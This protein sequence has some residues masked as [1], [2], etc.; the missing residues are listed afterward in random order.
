MGGLWK[1]DSVLLTFSELEEAP[2][3]KLRSGK[4][5]R[6]S[7]LM[8][9]EFAAAS[10]VTSWRIADII[11]KG[12]YNRPPKYLILIGQSRPS[13]EQL[14]CD[15]SISTPATAFDRFQDL[16]SNMDPTRRRY[17]GDFQSEHLPKDLANCAS[18]YCDTGLICVGDGSF[19]PKLGRGSHAWVLS[20]LADNHRLTGVGPADGNPATMSSYRPELHSILAI[21]VTLNAIRNSYN[22]PPGASVLLVCDNESAT[23]EVGKIVANPFYALDPQQTDCDLLLEIQG[24]LQLS[25]STFTV[26][27]IRGHQEDHAAIESLC[28]LSKLNINC[29]ER[30]KAYLRAHQYVHQPPP[31]ILSCERWGAVSSGQKI[32]TNILEVIHEQYTEP[33]SIA[34]LEKKIKWGATTTQQIAWLSLKYAKTALPLPRNVFVAKVMFDKLPVADRLNFFDSAESPLCRCCNRKTETQH[35]LFQ[36]RDKRCRSHRLQSWIQHTKVILTSGHTSRIIMDAIDVNVR[37]YL[38]LPDRQTK[39]QSSQ[40]HRS[41][42]AAVQ[43]AIADQG[44]IGWD[45]FLQGFISTRWEAA[46]MLYQELSGDYPEKTPRSWTA[47]LLP[48]LWN[49]SHAIWMYRNE[50]RHGVT[51]A[52]QA[53]NSRARVVT[54]VTDRYNHRPHLD[55]KYAW[56]YKAPLAKLLLQG[57]RALYAWLNSVNNL[58]SISSGPKQSTLHSHLFCRLSDEAMGR[59]RRPRRLRRLFPTSVSTSKARRRGKHILG[60]SLPTSSRL[61][62]NMWNLSV[63][64]LPIP[65]VKARPRKL[66]RWSVRSKDIRKMFDRGR[67][68]RI[69]T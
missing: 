69:M 2:S 12:H 41:V 7:Y 54:L 8:P 59:L 28:L 6:D 31:V 55:A 11:D 53:A 30:A 4:F 23:I 40:G 65:L 22:I 18:I 10:Q 68:K 16:L 49:F 3:R 9:L 13:A 52:E 14:P 50:V 34:Y 57:N 51:A 47:V 36:C 32:T 61:I 66:F 48:N 33:F 67:R 5:L 62:T 38:K 35:H 25:T 21:L 44:R 58:S 24:E 60:S 43:C 37:T 63:K 39:W 19:N 15:T 29:D 42:F 56:L 27:W 64:C 46:Q 1:Y 26:Q 17:I 20:H 45:K